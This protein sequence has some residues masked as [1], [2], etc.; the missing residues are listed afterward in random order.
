M[1]SSNH[2]PWPWSVGERKDKKDGSSY[3]RVNGGNWHGF[4]RV[5]VRTTIGEE[6]EGKKNLAL[7]LAA[8]DLLDALEEMARRCPCWITQDALDAISK[9]RG[10]ECSIY[11]APTIT[12]G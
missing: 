1:M 11:V 3:V 10:N 7:I 2:T 12:P 5:W 6:I 9:A 8:P 4:C